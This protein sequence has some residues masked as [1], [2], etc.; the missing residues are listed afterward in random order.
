MPGKLSE[1][2]IYYSISQSKEEERNLSTYKITS[3]DMEDKSDESEKTEINDPF[4][5]SWDKMIVISSESWFS[6]VC[7]IINI[8]LCLLSSWVYMHFAVF[9]N[10]ESITI[11]SIDLEIWFETIFSI[12]M[13]KEFIT[14][15]KT[16]G[17]LHVEKRIKFISQRYMKSS[18]G[19][20]VDIIPLFPFTFIFPYTSNRNYKL[21]YLLKQIRIKK[22]F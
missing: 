8:F 16:T 17:D 19:F 5:E 12:L 20:V 7:H 11:L 6:Y 10:E 3:F 14:D 13:L 1:K 4:K 21:F 18:S 22:G 15:F 9:G 2:E